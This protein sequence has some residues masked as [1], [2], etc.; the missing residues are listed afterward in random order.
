[1]LAASD[2]R[3]ALDRRGVR[4][5]ETSSAFWSR[6]T[7]L[8]AV[9]RLTWDN[10]LIEAPLHGRQVSDF[11]AA[12]DEEH[13]FALEPRAI[14]GEAAGRVIILGEAS[15]F[16]EP[17]APGLRAPYTQVWLWNSPGQSWTLAEMTVGRFV[18][19]S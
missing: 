8:N 16:A 4:S 18:P 15:R 17:P 13:R 10:Q 14:R 6:Y 9:T 1:V 19:A 7:G 12:R 5:Q 2:L 11:L 3:N